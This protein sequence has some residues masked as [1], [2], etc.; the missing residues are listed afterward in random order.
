MK[1]VCRHLTSSVFVLAFFALEIQGKSNKE[2]TPTKRQNYLD[3]NIAERNETFVA[4]TA[5]VLA[6]GTSL[7]VSTSEMVSEF[8]TSRSSSQDGENKR[9]SLAEIYR[10]RVLV[11]CRIIL[12][13]DS[14]LT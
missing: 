12:F 1:T 13:N 3:F 4:V 7:R 6:T 8:S 10:Y 2:D 5:N 9:V 14:I 11:S